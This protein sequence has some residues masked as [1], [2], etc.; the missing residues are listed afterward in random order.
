VADR[1][2]RDGAK[3]M[4][5]LTSIF[6]GLS[7]VVLAGALARPSD[8]WRF[9]VGASAILFSLY[10]FVRIA[11][12]LTDALDEGK[13]G[14][15]VNAMYCFNLAVLSAFGSIAMFVSVLGKDTLFFGWDLPLLTFHNLAA[16]IIMGAAFWRGPWRP[17]AAFLYR[18][19]RIGVNQDG[20]LV[21]VAGDAEWN[22]WIAS[23]MAKTDS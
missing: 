17:D 1:R 22:D 9:Y 15:Y 19:R 3:A 23:L 5:T 13:P 18:R 11:E 8:D 21:K 7:G 4:L 10:W 16:A 2:W 14:T 6:A 12:M 20:H